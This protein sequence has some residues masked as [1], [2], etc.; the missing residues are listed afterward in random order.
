V[1]SAID[2]D[3]VFKSKLLTINT[4]YQ[5]LQFQKASQPRTIMPML[6]P[7]PMKK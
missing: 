7:T 1:S 6:T 3:H 2:A 4:F 5:N